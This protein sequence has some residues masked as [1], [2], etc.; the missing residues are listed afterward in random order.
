MDRRFIEG[1]TVDL[2]IL[3]SEGASAHTT[4]VL[5]VSEEEIILRRPPTLNGA[6][7]GGVVVEFRPEGDQAPPERGE[8]ESVSDPRILK[9]R[10]LEL[11]ESG[12][13]RRELLR[14]ADEFPIEFRF[15][16]FS[17]HSSRKI[18]F[19][20]NAPASSASRVGPSTRSS[21]EMSESESLMLGCLQE[22]NHKFDRLVELMTR[23]VENETLMGTGM[24]CDISGS[25]LRFRMDRPPGKDS[26]LEIWIDF[27]GQREGPVGTLGEI[28]RVQ[29]DASPDGTPCWILAVHF[30]AVAESDRDRIVA[31]VLRRQRAELK[32]P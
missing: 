30:T 18:H 7:Q 27:P 24:I 29:K 14:Q 12:A 31:Y 6:D 28:K 17:E 32:S 23:R 8:I 19:E 20:L 13:Q 26:Y 21:E 9:L 2:S 25:G 4:S 5:D 10:R 22:M 16:S 1:Q 15:I 11:S 3:G